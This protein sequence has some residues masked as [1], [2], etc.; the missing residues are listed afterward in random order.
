MTRSMLLLM[1]SVINL[2]LGAL[3]LLFSEGVVEALGVPSTSLRFYPNILGGVLIGIG[4]ALLLEFRRKPGG[5]V[6]LGLGGAVVINLCGGIVLAA[7]LFWGDLQIPMKGRVFLW[8]L[9]VLLVGIS[10]AEVWGNLKR[11]NRNS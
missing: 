11:Q 5:L 9:V 3:L 1:D 7:W 6:G 2:A 4:L 8:S 10:L